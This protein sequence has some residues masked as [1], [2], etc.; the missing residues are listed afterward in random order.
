MNGQAGV[1]FVTQ[2][3]S[4]DAWLAAQ[5]E[6]YTLRDGPYKTSEGLTDTYLDAIAMI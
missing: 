1:E 6:K 3:E 4:R 2:A 5:V